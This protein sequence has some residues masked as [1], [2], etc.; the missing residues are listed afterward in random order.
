MQHGP[1]SSRRK[2]KKIAPP[3]PAPFTAESAAVPLLRIAEL[4]QCLAE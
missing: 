3:P 2:I 1:S 4:E